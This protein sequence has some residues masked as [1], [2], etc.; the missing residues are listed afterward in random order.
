MTILFAYDGSEGADDAIAAAAKLLNAPNADAV[1]LAV[2]EPMIV[3]ALRAARFGGPIP[4]PPDPGDQDERARQDARRIAEHGAGV[5]R[6][7]GFDARPIWVADQRKIAE[8]IVQDAAELGVDLIVLGARGLT[9]VRAFL[10]SVSNQ[11]LQH[12]HRPVL[13]VPPAAVPA[14]DEAPTDETPAKV[15][16]GS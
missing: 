6:E 5:A 8:T 12:A 9:G 11:V 1:V 14:E 3:E 13:V 15:V 2:W 16:V 4:M 10:G 7:L